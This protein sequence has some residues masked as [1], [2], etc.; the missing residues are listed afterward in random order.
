MRL[1]D[2]CATSPTPKVAIAVDVGTPEK[3]GPGVFVNFSGGPEWFLKGDG[4]LLTVNGTARG[5]CKEMTNIIQYFGAQEQAQAPKRGDSPKTYE[6]VFD[7]K[8]NFLY[9]DCSQ[10]EIKVAA[11]Y[12]HELFLDPNEPESRSTRRAAKKVGLPLKVAT[13]IYM[14]TSTQC[15]R[16]VN[17]YPLDGE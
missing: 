13:D 7:K 15:L 16:A 12:N 5:W 6:G 8:G 4:T 3:R 14:K 10:Y 9:P 17:T 2:T 1:A 11:I